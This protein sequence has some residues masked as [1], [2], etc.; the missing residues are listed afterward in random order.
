MTT[1]CKPLVSSSD[2]YSC[3]LMPKGRRQ[4]RGGLRSPGLPAP[5]ATL[6]AKAP[7]SRACAAPLA[8]APEMVL[9]ERLVESTPARRA[10][11]AAEEFVELPSGWVLSRN[12]GR[13]SSRGRPPSGGGP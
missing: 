6:V 4:G 9:L 11:P 10:D 8:G 12:G 1:P 3:S 5:D 13:S 7:L 2:L